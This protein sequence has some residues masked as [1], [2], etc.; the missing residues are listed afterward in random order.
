MVSKSKALTNAIFAHGLLLEHLQDY[1]VMPKFC[2][3][4]LLFKSG[5]KVSKLRLSAIEKSMLREL[6]E[7]EE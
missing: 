3:N 4:T 5:F 1:N 6:L 7:N 2:N